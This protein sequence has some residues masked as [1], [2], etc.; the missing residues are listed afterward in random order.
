MRVH[1]RVAAYLEQVHPSETGAIAHHWLEA[2]D[3]SDPAH[4]IDAVFQAAEQATERGGFDEAATLLARA[5]ARV[6]DNIKIDSTLG[7]E[8]RLR[9]GESEKNAGRSTYRD[10]LRTVARARIGGRRHAAASPRVLA[11]SRGSGSNSVRTDDEQI[12]LHEAALDAVGPGPTPDRAYLLSSL[13]IELGGDI[14]EGARCRQ[15][16]QEAF[17]IARAIVDPALRVDVNRAGI[18][19][20]WATATFD[21]PWSPTSTW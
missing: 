15:L 17:D 5:A 9:L 14:R 8:L 7:R 3:S 19:A 1:R 20:C 11:R 13:A 6:G 21:G 10:T 16:I 2:Q 4:T 12:A 18:F